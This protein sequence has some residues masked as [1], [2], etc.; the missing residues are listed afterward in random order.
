MYDYPGIRKYRL[1]F[2][3]TVMTGR[4][5]IAEKNWGQTG[6]SSA[7]TVIALITDLPTEKI[8]SSKDGVGTLIS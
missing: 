1:I 8:I 2:R 5:S 3:Q 7:M 6:E 4:I